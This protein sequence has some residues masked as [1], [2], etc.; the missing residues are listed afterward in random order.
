MTIKHRSTHIQTDVL[1]ER[2][3]GRKEKRE[4]VG[5]EEEGEG[6]GNIKDGALTSSGQSLPD[7]LTVKGQHFKFRDPTKP[8]QKKG[9]IRQG[10]RAD[11]RQ[12][13]SPAGPRIKDCPSMNPIPSVL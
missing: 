9:E 6:R 10:I 5:K 13:S 12:A 7:K 8:R 3:E 1:A 2:K 4:G 11:K